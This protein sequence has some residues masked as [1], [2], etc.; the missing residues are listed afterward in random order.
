MPVFLPIA[1]MS[2][3]ALP[4]IGAGALVGF[5]SG[6]L[7]VGGGFLLT[8]FL[9]MIGIPATVA[10]ASDANAIVA[11]SSSGV[12]AHFRLGHVD[13]RMGTVL[14]FGGLAGAAGG[15]GIIKVLRSVGNADVLIKLMYI[16]VLGS[17][18]AFMFADGIRKLRHGVMVREAAKPGRKRGLL[19]RLP[20]QM[21]FPHSGVRHSALVLLGVGF[22][23]GALSAVMGVGGGFLMIPT[24]VY[25]LG[26]SPHIAVGTS[27]FQVLFT[28]AGVSLLQTAE[29]HTVDLVL[30][31]TVAAGS[32]IAAQIGAAVTKRLRGD[33]LLII[34]SVLALAA[35][36]NMG[37]GLVLP[38]SSLLDPTRASWQGEAVTHPSAS[39]A[40][41]APVPAAAHPTVR[42]T[43][44]TVEIGATYDG[45]T[46]RIEGLASHGAEVV[47]VAR[48]PDRE[49]EFKRKARFGPIWVTRHTLRVFGAPSLFIRYTSE[50]LRNFLSSGEIERYELSPEAITRHMHLSPDDPEQAEVRDSYLKLKLKQRVYRVIDG[51]LHLGAPT[52]PGVPFWVQFHW[53]R[54]AP[55]AE[56]R[57]WV[58]ECRN[59]VVTSTVSVPLK[60][61]EVG[62]PAALSLLLAKEAWL[63]GVAAVAAAMIFGFLI[64]FLLA[65]ARRTLAR[66]VPRAVTQREERVPTPGLDE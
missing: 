25:L 11:T 34:L 65:R 29:N 19:R 56:Y 61:V 15:V 31:L 27:L 2:V 21:N 32:T 52:D 49:E 12:A 46:M 24:M 47:V 3:G 48:G 36:L 60:V 35:A 51:G 9:I 23:I 43:P 22:L 64:D 5:L 26:M 44:A 17:V 58:Y 6:L 10:A 62:F 20:F 45:A 4:L 30:A 14:L 8:P 28:C 63:Y 50:P 40:S 7:G 66:S 57:V 38:P 54:K 33:Q 42:L 1:G 55:P 18:G 59:G 41:A 16:V 37:F 13:F 53:P 39:D